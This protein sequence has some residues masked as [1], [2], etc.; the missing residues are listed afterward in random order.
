MTET[1]LGMPT[2]VNGTIPGARV[3]Q[4]GQPRTRR[5]PTIQQAPPGWVTRQIGRL[6]GEA[7]LS[8]VTYLGAYVIAAVGGSQAATG[9]LNWP[10]QATIPAWMFLELLSVLTSVHADKRRQKGERA[11][12]AQ[13]LSAVF[14]LGMATLN[15]FG[16]VHSNVFQAALFAGSSLAAYGLYLLQSGARRRDRLRDEKQI[17][18]VA[19]AYGWL[20]WLLHPRITAQA[21]RLA[22]KYP[23]LGLHGSLDAVEAARESVA[24]DVALEAYF[25]DRLAKD[26]SPAEVEA[27][28]KLYRPTLM[29]PL[30][31][32]RVDLNSLA[33]LIAGEVGAKTVL[34]KV[35][36]PAPAAIRGP[37][38][39]DLPHPGGQHSTRRHR[40]ATRADV[41]AG[42]R[43]RL[44]AADLLS[45]SD[46][47]RAQYPNDSAEEHAA[48]LG[49]SS[50]R[51][52]QVRRQ[53]G[54]VV[55]STTGEQ[56]VVARKE[57]AS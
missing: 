36:R 9:I 6:H 3:A 42:K 52:R 27:L 12:I 55:D 51:V 48:R 34:G 26:N 22:I 57:H 2:T 21:K 1:L 54:Q 17:A 29:V 46:Q 5:Q 43:E 25:R 33:D 19:P 20:Q 56:P 38:V 15:W 37:R 49:V 40:T 35:A 7:F 13:A 47:F 8:A 16:H 14:A 11:L 39:D 53:F 44:S 50:A 32:E 18:D 41:P 28:L 10:L 4:A 30:L 24:A 23:H 31:R 45:L